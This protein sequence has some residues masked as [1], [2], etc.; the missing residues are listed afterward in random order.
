MFFNF[1]CKSLAEMNGDIDTKRFCALNA[2]GF[3]QNKVKNIFIAQK[4]TCVFFTGSN[5]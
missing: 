5:W 4:K 3:G 1:D 2:S